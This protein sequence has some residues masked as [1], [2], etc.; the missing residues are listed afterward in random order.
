M[1]LLTLLAALSLAQEP[2]D[3]QVPASVL[4]E[5]HLLESRFD[6]ALAADCDPERCVSKGC[7]YVAHA[8]AD[9]PARTSLPG[10]AKEPGPDAVGAQEY[11]TGARCTFAWEDSVSARD[12]PALAS[13]L[14]AK[15]SRGWLV[16]TV[17]GE[18]LPPLPDYLRNPPPEP[19]P[20]VEPEPEPEPE[21]IEDEPEAWSPMRE[22]W[23]SLLP[24]FFWMVGVALVTLAATALIWAWRRVGRRTVEEE[25]LLQELAGPEASEE[26][27][28]DTPAD[29]DAVEERAAAWRE[30][31]SDPDDPELHALLGALLRSG[32]LPL[33]ARAAL[34]FPDLPAAFPEGG[35][36]ATAKLEL[37]A[38]LETVDEAELPQGA[39]FYRALD[40]HAL[41]AALGAQPDARLLASLHEDF[42]AAGLAELVQALPPRTGGL[43]LALAS[44]VDQREIV[45][46]LDA[47]RAAALAAG[48]LGSDRVDPAESSQLFAVV[49][50]ARDGRPLPAVEALPVTDRG[51]PYDAVGALS[52]LLE[53]LDPARRAAALAAAVE[54]FHGRLPAWHRGIL[55]ADWLLALPDEARVDLLLSVD[56]E[57]L[58]GWSSLLLP[59]VRDRI[60][61]GIPTALHTAIRAASS[62]PSPR[63]Q[64]A[65]AA[66]GRRALARGLTAQLAR[67]GD[68]FESLVT[69]G[70]AS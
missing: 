42:G 61:A 66:L 25:L 32:D 57:S 41:S 7:A 22:L 26:P 40:R 38:F 18:S 37:A 56:A 2:P 39:A 27:A 24:H 10:L 14:E 48:L 21:P 35:A 15:L 16:V 31:V 55:V 34:E 4:A 60:L 51:A 45:R 47:D 1:T 65:L 33:L 13:R 11:L 30:R 17:E 43:L 68:T 53:S 28:T 52:V 19:E 20:V 58:A 5:V 49:S 67:R 69:G 12:V 8:V 50:A 46:L 3:R 59:E 54:R 64:V 9:R 62:F 70:P 44:P 29:D 23:A 36:Y 63:R 6:V